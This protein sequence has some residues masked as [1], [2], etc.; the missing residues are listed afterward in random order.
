MRYQRAHSP[1][2]P[3]DVSHSAVLAA[4]DEHRRMELEPIR[5]HDFRRLLYIYI[6]IDV[7]TNSK[8]AKGLYSRKAFMA[9]SPL[10]LENSACH[11]PLHSVCSRT[12]TSTHVTR[13]KKKKKIS[14]C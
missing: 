14:L 7:Q 2:S 11:M 6:Y 13:K 3:V 8:T 9:L 1:A 4:V 5:H 10:L 12:V